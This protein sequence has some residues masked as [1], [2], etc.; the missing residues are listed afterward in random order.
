MTGGSGW[1]A[2]WPKSVE[3]HQRVGMISALCGGFWER[4]SRHEQGLPGAPAR[5]ADEPRGRSG[6]RRGLA[7]G[8]SLEAAGH[9]TDGGLLTMRARNF[10]PLGGT[11]SMCWL[12]AGE[13]AT[14]GEGPNGLGCVSRRPQWVDDLMC[15]LCASVHLSPSPCRS[16]P[17]APFLVVWAA[18]PG[19]V[20]WPKLR[21]RVSG[22]PASGK[23]LA[24]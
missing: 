9:W 16:S 24:R 14:K 10:G 22:V 17:L 2:G 4:Q 20:P 12:C 3:L 23:I 1:Q 8:R 5:S 11:P 15:R 7:P 19:A 13:S 21:P 18:W 6:R